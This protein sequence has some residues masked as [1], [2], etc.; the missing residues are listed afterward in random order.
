LAYQVTDRFTPGGEV[1]DN[2]FDDIGGTDVDAIFNL[3]ARSALEAKINPAKGVP[4]GAPFV[5]SKPGFLRMRSIMA[6]PKALSFNR[7][8]DANVTRRRHA[9]TFSRHDRDTVE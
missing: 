7:H 9:G 8:G 5:M 4:Q 3:V 6:A 2:R 1:L